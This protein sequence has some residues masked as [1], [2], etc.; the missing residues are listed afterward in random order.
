M[1]I[2][3]MKIAVTKNVRVRSNVFGQL[4]ERINETGADCGLRLHQLVDEELAGHRQL[5]R[6]KIGGEARIYFAYAGALEVHQQLDR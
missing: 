6:E 1:N 5:V 2:L 3:A 4:S